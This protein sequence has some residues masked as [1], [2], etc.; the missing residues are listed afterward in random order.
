MKLNY[1]R[2]ILVGL[3]F[4][5]ICAFWQLYD[6]VI[7]LILKNTFHMRDD[8]AGVIMAGILAATIALW[9]IAGYAF[10]ATALAS[11][12]PLP[13]RALALPV[14]L[15]GALLVLGQA[16]RSRRRTEQAS[17]P[18]PKGRIALAV[19]FA[20]VGALRGARELRE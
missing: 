9:A 17:P 4:L 5:S 15:A 19:A 20:A 18:V 2:T 6:N 11:A 16:A 14:A 7:P 12:A 1:K 13:I 3:A 8:I 10:C